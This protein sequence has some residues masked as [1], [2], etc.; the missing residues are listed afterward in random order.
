MED[1]AR[2]VARATQKRKPMV[3]DGDALWMLKDHPELAL[4]SAS[5][6][7]TAMM[8]LT[9]NKVE[10]ERLYK[11][12]LLGGP[13][14]KGEIPASPPHDYDAAAAA[15][16]AAHDDG[17]DTDERL[18]P[19]GEFVDANSEFALPVSQLA[20]ALGGVVVVRKGPSDVISDGN[21]AVIV[22]GSGSARR[23][24]GQG[25]VLAGVL[26]QFLSWTMPSD[27][28]RGGVLAAYAACSL[29]RGANRLAYRDH[30]RGMVTPDMIG[31]LS[32]AFRRGGFEDDEVANVGSRM[33]G[34]N[35]M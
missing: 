31:R 28:A 14:A 5:T 29:T 13:G 27:P 21:T 33:C 30:G 11:A 32:E 1:T 22:S 4:K 17:G 7:G 19:R 15:A 20:R 18:I 34:G 9:P 25:D 12:M 3:L 35:K 26:G 23:C 2:M 16:A 10:F 24:G 8:V 6:S